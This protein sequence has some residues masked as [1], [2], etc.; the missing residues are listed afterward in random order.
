MKILFLAQRV[1]YSPNKRDN[2][3]SFHLI[4]H[5]AQRHQIAFACLADPGQEHLCPKI[6]IVWNMQAIRD[7]TTSDDQL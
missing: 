7:T 2:P 4:K 3:R 5:F 1:P 6:K